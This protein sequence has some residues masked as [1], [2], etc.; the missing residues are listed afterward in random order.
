MVNNAPITLQQPTATPRG[1]NNAPGMETTEVMNDEGKQQLY[2][3][4]YLFISLN[5]FID[6]KMASPPCS[7]SHMLWG[8]S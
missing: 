1:M 4:I 3:F 7:P 5:D 6:I 8:A 2:L